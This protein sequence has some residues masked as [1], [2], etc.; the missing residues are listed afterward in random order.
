M[1]LPHKLPYFLSHFSVFDKQYGY[2]SVYEVE[3]VVQGY[4][5]ANIPLDTQWMDIGESW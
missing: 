4:K 5:N 3:Q 2:T 1:F